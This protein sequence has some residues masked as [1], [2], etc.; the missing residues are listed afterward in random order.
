MFCA[1]SDDGYVT[2]VDGVLRKTLCAGDRT[3]LTE[4]RLQAGSALPVHEHV[5]EQSGYLVTGHLLLTIGGER[6]DVR[7]GAGWT[8]PG[9]VEHG[10]EVLADSV[11]V[12][13]FSP[14]RSDY[15]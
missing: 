13:V 10:A 11:A 6:H 4:F 2:V 9:G 7:P 3:L 14:P 8:I 15:L 5:Y 1:P 12:E